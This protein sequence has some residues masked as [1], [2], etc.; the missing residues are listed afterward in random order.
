MI[1]SAESSCIDSS[2]IFECTDIRRD[3]GLLVKTKERSFK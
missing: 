2:I 1:P 3:T